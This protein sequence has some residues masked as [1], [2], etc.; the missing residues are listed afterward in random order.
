MGEDNNAESRILDRLREAEVQKALACVFARYVDDLQELIVLATVENGGVRPKGLTNEIYSAF[1]HL[2]RGLSE[3]HTDFRDQFKSARESHLKRAI[4]DS[5]KIAINS[6][7]DEDNKLLETLYYIVLSE[8]FTRY[9]PDGLE[10][11]QKIKDKAA[12]VKA[13]Y[14]AA[15][16]EERRGDFDA[17]ITSYNT[18][19]ERAYELQPLIEV[20]T[21]DKTYL[22]ACA[23]EVKIT[24]E[25]QK[26]RRN[27]IYAAVISAV[28]TAIL[29]LLVTSCIPQN[30]TQT[31][32]ATPQAVTPPPSSAPAPTPPTP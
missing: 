31:N 2:A 20:F 26:D 1:H 14:K 5:Y 16:H 7:L 32:N 3:D 27:T 22:L 25:K 30:T 4:L 17:A 9:I 10:K 21:R 15:M 23:R 11:T 19:L 12:S 8:D 28:V 24:K 13:A 6:I 29:T 18:S